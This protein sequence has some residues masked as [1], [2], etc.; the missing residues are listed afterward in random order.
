VKK[1]K[2]KLKPS[3]RVLETVSH[4]G[5]CGDCKQMKVKEG[6]VKLKPKGKFGVQQ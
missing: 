1:K 2:A 4:A 3:Y 6:G 5:M